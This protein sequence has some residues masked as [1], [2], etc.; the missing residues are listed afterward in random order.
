M[1]LSAHKYFITLIRWYIYLMKDLVCKITDV[2]SRFA[3]KKPVYKKKSN[4]TQLNCIIMSRV[5]VPLTLGQTS[6]IFEKTKIIWSKCQV[7]SKNN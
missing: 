1:N 5:G 6:S 3:A 7:K 4:L 2:C